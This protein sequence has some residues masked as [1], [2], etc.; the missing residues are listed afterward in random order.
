MSVMELTLWFVWILLPLAA[1]LALALLPRTSGIWRRRFAGA[2]AAFLGPV[3]LLLADKY[4]LPMRGVALR[5]WVFGCLWALMTVGAVSVLACAAFYLHARQSGWIALLAQPL[6]LLGCLFTLWWS[7]FYFAFSV[8]PD[9]VVEHDG[10]RFI[11]VDN[12]FLD[13]MYDYYDYRSLFLRG[14]EKR[15]SWG[16]GS[17]WGDPWEDIRP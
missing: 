14:N 13:E 7:F 15:K 4:L 8:R 16:E 12:S 6:A 11:E 1:V 5:S 17:W 3:L 10:Q 9:R 2:L